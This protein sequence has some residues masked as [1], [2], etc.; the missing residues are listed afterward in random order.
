MKF[1]KTIV[2]SVLALGMGSAFAN[3]PVA[4]TEAQMDKVSAG[5]LALAQAAAAANGLLQA[6]TLTQTA[7]AVQ[8]IAILQ[9]QG[10]QITQ[11]LTQSASHSEGAAI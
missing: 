7:T 2:A 4:L 9:T 3:E 8:V 6:A 1:T 10:G 5:G 11:D